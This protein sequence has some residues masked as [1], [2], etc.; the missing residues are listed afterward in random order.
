MSRINL[1]QSQTQ[2]ALITSNINIKS[3]IGILIFDINTLPYIRTYLSFV[4]LELEIV[5]FWLKAQD[6][7]CCQY[8]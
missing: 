8:Y 1:L 6:K 2:L 5:C 4:I 7:I 3:Y